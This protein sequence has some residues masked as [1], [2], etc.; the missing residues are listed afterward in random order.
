MLNLNERKPRLFDWSDQLRNSNNDK[1]LAGL[2]NGW[3]NT[4]KEEVLPPYLDRSAIA[5]LL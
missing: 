2:E 5:L 1:R 4:F 3:A